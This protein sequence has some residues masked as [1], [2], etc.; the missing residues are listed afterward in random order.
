[1]ASSRSVSV[2]LPFSICRLSDFSMAAMV[3]SAVDW[4]RDRSITSNPLT[5]AVS[6]MPDPMIP[7]PTIATR[8]IDIGD[9]ASGA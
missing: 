6:A 7:D 5:A 1:M 9:D 4:W 8:V 2:L 3:A